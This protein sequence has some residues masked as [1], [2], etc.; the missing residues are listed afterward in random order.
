[1]DKPDSPQEPQ[2]RFLVAS[3]RSDSML[4]MRIFAESRVC[5]VTSRLI[6]T[7]K[8]GEED[9]FSPNCSI[10]ENCSHQ[11]VY[12]DA[13]EPGKRFLV[14]KEELGKDSSKEE[15]LYDPYPMP[16][17]F[18]MVRLVFLIR[19]PIRIFDSWK[20]VGENDAQ[21]LLHCY[22]NLFRII[23]QAPAH[24]VSYLLYEHF[25]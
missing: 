14:S 9:G 22:T 19:D 20:N 17:T 11:D 5:E 4:L 12:I 24:A 25:I 7:S 8:V 2:I 15:C 1:M 13:M 3:S 16:S 6:L 21:S 23:D 10:L 18:A